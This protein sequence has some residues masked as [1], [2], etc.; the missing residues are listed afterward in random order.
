MYDEDL[1]DDDVI[2][3]WAGK[4]D[5]AKGLGVPIEAARA[6]RKS[7]APIVDWLQ[8]EEDDDEDED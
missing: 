4:E 5:A 2:L 8:E 7:A 3:A 6:V 1:A